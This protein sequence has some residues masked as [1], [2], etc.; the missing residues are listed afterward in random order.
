M[1]D[2]AVEQYH[3]IGKDIV[4]F[5]TLFWPAM[6][7]FSGAQDADQRVRPRLPHRVRREDVEVARHRRQPAA[8]LRARHEPRVAALLHRRQAE[9]PRRGPRLQPRRLRRARE[10]RP[11]RQVR[12]HREPGGEVRQQALR[13]RAGVRR[14]GRRGARRRGPRSSADR[15]RTIRRAPVRAGG[16]RSDGDRRP[17][18]RGVR[19][20]EAVGARQGSGAPRRAA[21][22]LLARVARVQAPHRAAGTHSSCD[23]IQGRAR[24]LRRGARFRVVRRRSSARAHRS[25]FAS[26]RA[27]RSEADRRAAVGPPPSPPSAPLRAGEGAARAARPRRCRRAEARRAPRPP[28]SPSTTSP[29]STCASR[30]SSTPSTSTARRSC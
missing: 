19:P 2:P 24:V 20:G 13:R 10:Q 9:R 7:R 18:Q 25:V 4:Y 5:H 6:L 17:H 14:E 1:A 11:R 21:G 23:R 15:V 3:F 30:A 12:E 27:H 28:R 22:R 16:A 26:D 29:R 8:V